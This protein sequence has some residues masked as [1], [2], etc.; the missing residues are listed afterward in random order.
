MFIFV[1]YYQAANTF[2]DTCFKGIL[3]SSMA[4]YEFSAIGETPKIP[5]TE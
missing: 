3:T 4:D 2:F 1:G 5:R